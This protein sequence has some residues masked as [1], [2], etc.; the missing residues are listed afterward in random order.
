MNDVLDKGEAFPDRARPHCARTY[1]R[2]LAPSGPAADDHPLWPSWTVGRLGYSRGAPKLLHSSDLSSPE[3][4]CC[5]P[6]VLRPGRLSL[7]A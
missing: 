3:L 1:G 7:N 2:T 6:A 5:A 4:V